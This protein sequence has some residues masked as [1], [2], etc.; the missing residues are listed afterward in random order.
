MESFYCRKP[1][2]VKDI[3]LNSIW[4]SMS[5][6]DYKAL[7]TCPTTFKRSQMLVATSESESN[8]AAVIS[9]SPQCEQ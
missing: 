2:E 8:T 9:K 7:S 6:W 1:Q 5:G 4:V 3:A